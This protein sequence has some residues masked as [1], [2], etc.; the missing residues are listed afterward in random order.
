MEPVEFDAGGGQSIVVYVS[1]DTGSEVDAAGFYAEI[2]A[3][4]ARRAAQ[5]QR[6]VSVA[7]V[8]TRHAQAF[9]ARQGSGY[10]TKLAVA[11]VYAAR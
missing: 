10:E 11:V 3:D 9:V 1:A 4:S 5:G 8:P 2:A 6:I 7:A